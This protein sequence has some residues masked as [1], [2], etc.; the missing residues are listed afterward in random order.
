MTAALCIM[1][2]GIFSSPEPTPHKGKDGSR[3]SARACVCACVCVCVCVCVDIFK[4]E[5][6]CNQQAGGNQI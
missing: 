3:A 6:L 2:T 4:H 1:F 5:Y